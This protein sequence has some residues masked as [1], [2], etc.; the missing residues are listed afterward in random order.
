[1]AAAWALAIRQMKQVKG[2][3]SLWRWTDP[4]EGAKRIVNRSSSLARRHPS[5][6]G[7]LWD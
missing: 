7:W 1:M 5:H 3:V 2:V 4:R 6:D